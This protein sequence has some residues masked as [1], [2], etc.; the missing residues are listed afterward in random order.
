VIPDGHI[1]VISDEVDVT[2]FNLPRFKIPIAGITEIGLID[3]LPIHKELPVTK[4]NLFASQG[5]H[6]F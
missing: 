3:D 1:P 4:F 2:F 6:A 5:H